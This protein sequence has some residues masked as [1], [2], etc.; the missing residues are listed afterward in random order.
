M[1]KRPSTVQEIIDSLTERFEQFPAAL[2]VA[3]RLLIDHPRDVGMYSMRKLAARASVHPNA[4]VRLAREL[5]FDGYDELRERYR[6]FAVSDEFAGFGARSDWLHD[7][8][9]E[10]GASRVVAEM[11]EAT[12]ENLQRGLSQQN[13]AQ[14][15]QVCERIRSANHVYILGVGA[16]YS[17]AHQFWYVARMA[18]EHTSLI[19]R[20]GSHP[21]DDLA[22]IGKDDMLIA[23]TF[24]PYRNETIAALELARKKRL[25]VVGITDSAAS[26]VARS[27][28]VSLV[29]PTHTPHF[30]ASHAAVTALLE[31]LLAM[32]IAQAPASIRKRIDAFHQ[33]RES[34]GLYVEEFPKGV[35]G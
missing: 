35:R 5:G 12:T 13:V 17:L 2:Q 32:L 14:L 8:H 28:D 10:G 19:P 22:H 18:F 29:C 7:L 33:Q 4:F 25:Y 27:A 24:Q 6:D 30:F 1:R 16:A 26:P 20:L 31:T 9:G 23:L 15:E 34:A 11:A 3:A 21:L